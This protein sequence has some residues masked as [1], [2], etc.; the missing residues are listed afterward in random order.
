MSENSQSKR[1]RTAD[2]VKGAA[3]IGVVVLHFAILQAHGSV[4]SEGITITSFK[5][6]P[7]SLMCTFIIIS[8]YFYV[9]GR[10]FVDN[11]KKRILRF[12]IWLVAA[13]VILNTVMFLILLLQGYN[14]ELSSL[15][16][17]ISQTLV[18]KG[19]FTNIKESAVYGAAVLAPFEVTHPLYYLEMLVV[20]YVIFYAIAD[21]VI[22]DDRK[23]LISAFILITISAVYV[24]FVGTLLPF[25]AHLGPMSAGFLLIG[26]FLKKKE[27]Y[28]WIE[29]SPMN[30]K[31]WGLFIISL[32]ISL[33][34]CLVTPRDV[35]ILYCNF[36]DYGVL[37][38]YTF[39]IL[40]IFGGIAI[41]YILSWLGRLKVF[42][43]TIGKVGECCLLVFVLHM[44]VGKCLAAPFVTYDT[45]CWFPI[46][47]L[48]GI[49]LAVVTIAIITIAGEYYYSHKKKSKEK[50][51][52]P[53]A[54]NGD[55]PAN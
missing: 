2:M 11:L 44:F 38:F 17:V 8:G 26:V 1:V 48:Q 36:G 31:Y 9:P 18:G 7:Y 42:Y 46:T 13:V 20:G 50:A 49:I 34:L 32:V 5:A 33:S 22:D 37:S 35:S 30:K 55:I 27:F 4:P 28:R 15:W 47:T 52:A 43:G 10:S 3:I 6:F 45:T 25:Y 14:L 21:R 40:S 16:N 53:E 39:S 24:V 41:T 23:L 54:S 19:A 12:I 29:N 51:S